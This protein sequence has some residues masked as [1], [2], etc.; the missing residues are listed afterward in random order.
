MKANFISPSAV[1]QPYIRHY[2]VIESSG[3]LANRVLP[4]TSL[5]LAFRFRGNINYT[6]EG[7]QTNLPA[8]V[9]SGLRNSARIINYSP[10][11]GAVLVVFKEALAQALFKVPA[12]EFF[13]TSIALDNLIS[14]QKSAEFEERLA[15][16]ADNTRRIAIVEQLLLSQLTYITPDKLVLSAVQKIGMARGYI[17]IKDLANSL[18]ISQDAFEK[19]F[20]KTIGATPKQFSSITRM[21]SLVGMAKQTQNLSALAFNAGY[22]DQPHFNKDFK[23]FTGLTPT[24]FFRSPVF[25]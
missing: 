17:K 11:S 15:G 10:N 5:V 6:A 12:H 3:N 13:N 18:Y 16:A 4:D 2:I 21:R 23:L 7:L 1:L 8:S 20:R 24:D 19:R 9:V 14:R 25:W 22:F